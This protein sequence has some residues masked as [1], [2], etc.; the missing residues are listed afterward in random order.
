MHSGV[1]FP[2]KVISSEFRSKSIS[3]FDEIEFVTYF[4]EKCFEIS[5]FV[6]K[7]CTESDSDVGIEILIPKSKSESEFRCRNQ[8]RNSDFNIETEIEILISTSK[9]RRNQNEISSEFRFRGNKLSK[10][11][12][13]SKFRFRHR[14]RMQNFDK[15]RIKFRRNFDFVESKKTTIVETLLRSAKH[16]L[17]SY[18]VAN[19]PSKKNHRLQ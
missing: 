6:L 9:F 1:G 4:G 18:F 8:N 12:L 3:T 15:I 11:K 19:S 7:S 2:T 17:T 10:S 14:N 13:K 16:V 5:T